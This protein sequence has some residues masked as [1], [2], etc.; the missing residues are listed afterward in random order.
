AMDASNALLDRHRIPGQVVIEQHAGA[1]KIDALAACRSGDEKLRTVLIPKPLGGF[2]LIVQR[3]ALDGG[4]F[5]CAVN[6]RQFDTEK[7][8]RLAILREDDEPFAFV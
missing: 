7:F 6:L 8:Q 3:P 4:D 1:L 5:V 2:D